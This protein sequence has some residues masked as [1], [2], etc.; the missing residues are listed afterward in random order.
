VV[1]GGL[2]PGGLVPGGLVAGA[3]VAG[4][5]VAGVPG[6]HGVELSPAQVA[7]FPSEAKAPHDVALHRSD[8][9]RCLCCPKMVLLSKKKIKVRL[10]SRSL[11]SGSH[12]LV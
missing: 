6:V 3:L 11:Q 12:V 10:F 1:A 9:C 8:T 2:V 5:F 4:G 7:L